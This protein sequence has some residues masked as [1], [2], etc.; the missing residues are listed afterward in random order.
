M[1]AVIKAKV[2]DDIINLPISGRGTAITH[3]YSLS[4]IA[5]QVSHRCILCRMGMTLTTAIRVT[6]I[7][8]I[9]LGTTRYGRE[10]DSL[11]RSILQRIGLGVGR[12]LC[13]NLIREP[14]KVDNLCPGRSDTACSR[15]RLSTILL[16]VLLDGKV[17]GQSLI[18]ACGKNF[19]NAVFGSFY[20]APSKNR[21]IR[22][23]IIVDDIL[24]LFSI[25]IKPCSHIIGNSLR[26]KR[27]LFDISQNRFYAIVTRHDDITAVTSGIE[28]II[29][30]FLLSLRGNSTSARCPKRLLGSVHSFTFAH[31]IRLGR[32]KCRLLANGFGRCHESK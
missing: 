9:N 31:H 21:R 23:N 20:L 25:P 8:P 5:H 26:I 19:R 32:V 14:V 30:G 24:Y 1:A 3:L 22:I 4:A 27:T 2:L 16:V 11:L 28:D 18:P 17:V 7:V 10:G 15:T 12:N 6:H 13:F 29:V